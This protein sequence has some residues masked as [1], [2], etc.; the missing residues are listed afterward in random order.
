MK[1]NKS[2]VIILL[3]SLVLSLFAFSACNNNPSSSTSNSSSQPQASVED[4][5]I[6]EEDSSSLEDSS[7]ENSQSSSSSVEEVTVTVS[8]FNHDGSEL[9]SVEVKEGSIPSYKGATPTKE[10]TV[11]MEYTF[12]G[13]S[14]EGVV[15]TDLPAVSV[16]SNFIAHFTES[17]R[18]YTVTF[19][20]N[21]EEISSLYE[22]GTMPSYNGET[23]F[24]IEGEVYLLTGWDKTITAVAGDCTYE[25]VLTYRGPVE[26]YN[27]TFVVDESSIVVAVKE[28]CVPV[29]YGEPYRKEKTECSYRFIGW[30]SGDVVYEELPVA[31]QNVTYTAVFETVY[32]QF[33]VTFKHEGEPVQTVSVKYGEVPVY[34]GIQLTKPSDSKYDYSLA[35]WIR[36]GEVYYGELPHVYEDMAFESVFEKTL[37][38]YNVTVNYYLD[39]VIF[40]SYSQNYICGDDCEIASPAVD[41]YSPS[42]AYVSGCVVE[43]RTVDV[44]YKTYDV[45][46]GEYESVTLYGEGTQSAPYI[47]T[48]AEQLAQLAKDV[49]GGKAYESVYF[50]LNN[51][52]DLANIAW[53]AIG[54]YNYPFGGHFDGNGHSVYNLSYRSELANSNA[55]SGHALFSTVSGS[56]KNLNV[57]G[58]VYSVA[59]YTALVVGHNNGGLV[60][61]CNSFGTVCGFGNTAG[62]VG[63]SSG[64]IKNCNNYATI[65]QT[66]ASG[67]YRTA[68]IVGGT[69]ASVSYCNN[70]GQVIVDGG[71]GTVAGIVARKEGSAV[72]SYC[73]NYGYVSSTK[74]YVG[75]VIG[76]AIGLAEAINNCNNYAPVYGAAYTSGVVGYIV[77]TAIESCSNYG[78]V[79]GSSNVGGIVGYT[80]ANVTNCENVGYIYGTS[81]YVGGVVG[82]AYANVHN[83]VNK[84]DVLAD[85]SSAGGVIGYFYANKDLVEVNGVKNCVNFGSVTVIVSGSNANVGGVIGVAAKVDGDNG[86]YV[87]PY[88][89]D[90]VNHGLVLSNAN[91]T[92]GV[93]GGCNGALV[94]N[95]VNHANVI[96]ESGSYVAGIAGSNWGYGSVS[97]CTNYGA[98]L[99]GATVGEICGQLTSTSTAVGNNSL[100][101]LL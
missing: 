17:A 9:Y 52:L 27:V 56:V 69:N 80:K 2:L 67:S 40:D 59:K 7:G 29:F 22:Y 73:N 50:K 12:A 101:K 88:V 94:K 84:G 82:R 30:K 60:Q 48:T 99:G 4:S 85:A 19:M 72:I 96:S 20:V 91:Y 76:Y 61:N 31:T 68:G 38:V 14:L 39:G 93:L 13:W 36:Y 43:D 57:S 10:S 79:K 11:S 65:T 71:S 5:S 46:T 49:D 87:K 45:W 64:E 15:Y 51:D 16:D 89:E 24:E 90:C 37:R 54:H 1:K 62:I 98:I 34:S 21:G 81:N 55:N 32:K 63:W 35:G 6:S 47:I 66:G 86:D 97:S 23:K 53:E 77:E 58:N 25:A 8:F 75:G 41:G 3:L 74:N 33:T 42:F 100:G 70:Y 18:K 95:C 44:H 28:D 78:L 92:G 26:Y 83:C